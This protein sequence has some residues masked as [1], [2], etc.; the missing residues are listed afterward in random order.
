MRPD[1]SWTPGSRHV[2]DHAEATRE[3]VKG[4]SFPSVDEQLSEKWL[5]GGVQEFMLGVANVFKDAG[6][7]PEAL[8]TYEDAVNAG[9][10]TAAS[11]M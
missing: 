9:P 2:E 5:G 8:D 4:F 11:G 6:S 3:Y 7:I 1:G 10:L